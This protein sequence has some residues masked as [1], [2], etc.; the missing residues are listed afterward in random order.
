MQQMPKST[1]DHSL[2]EVAELKTQLKAAQAEAAELQKRLSALQ[3]EQVGKTQPA[4]ASA[5]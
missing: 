5:T 4:P 3:D 2:Q 1:S